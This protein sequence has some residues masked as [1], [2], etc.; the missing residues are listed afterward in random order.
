MT[1]KQKIE[2]LLSTLPTSEKII[3][4]ESLGKKYRRE[5]SMRINN[6]QMGRQLVD[7]RPDELALKA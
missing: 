4:L 5:N 6:K 1:M 2:D 7:E 3:I